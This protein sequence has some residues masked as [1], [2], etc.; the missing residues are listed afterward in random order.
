MILEVI[1][2]I[3]RYIATFVKAQLIIIGIM[4]AV[5]ALTL[6]FSG[7][8]HG[9]LWG[10]LAGFLDAL[11][12]VGTGIVLIPLA[13]VQIFY[14]YYGRAVVCIVLY[15]ACIFLRELLEPRLIGRR[16]GVTPIAV[17]ASLYAGI[18][19]FG[20]WGIIKGPLGFVMI[21][22]TYRSLRKRL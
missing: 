22:E 13:L 3:I 9:V 16:I 15:L 8:R 4:A 12:F 21:Y 11:P 5:A 19:L 20:V 17:L 7:I 14:G 6:G 1:C 2:G 10:I 18:Q